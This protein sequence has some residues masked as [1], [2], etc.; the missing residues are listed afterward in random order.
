[1]DGSKCLVKA[2]LRNRVQNRSGQQ[3]HYIDHVFTTHHTIVTCQFKKKHDQQLSEVDLG[4][5]QVLALSL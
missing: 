2:V 5:M 4:E 1:M 3:I